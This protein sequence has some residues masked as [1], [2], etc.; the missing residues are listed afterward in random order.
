[1]RNSLT[2]SMIAAYRRRILAHHGRFILERLIGGLGN[3]FRK[4]RNE[5]LRISAHQRVRIVHTNLEGQIA[6]Y[7]G[8][9]ERA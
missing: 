3:F 7:K 9:E 6:G 4:I 2:L 8:T 1:M 5:W